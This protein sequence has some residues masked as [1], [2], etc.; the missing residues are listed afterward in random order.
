[1]FYARQ[2]KVR[3]L[4]VAMIVSLSDIPPSIIFGLSVSHHIPKTDSMT[5]ARLWPCSSIFL[6]KFSINNHRFC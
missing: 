3:C 5:Y 6:L 4:C 1:M 2:C